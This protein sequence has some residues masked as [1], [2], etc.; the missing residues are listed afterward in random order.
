MIQAET[1]AA[2][3]FKWSEKGGRRIGH[4]V[5][6]GGSLTVCRRFDRADRIQ[7]A[8]AIRD[9]DALIKDLA[10]QGFHT[11]VEAMY[12]ALQTAHRL[13]ASRT[14][15]DQGVDGRT[16]VVK[17]ETRRLIGQ[18]PVSHGLVAG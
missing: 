16:V 8:P 10:G 13:V 18:L 6:F 14:D 3:I 1:G 2:T 7:T 12:G 5:R 15:S 17:D 11:D 9:G 4:G